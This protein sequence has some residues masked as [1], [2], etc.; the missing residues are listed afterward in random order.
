MSRFDAMQLRSAFACF[1][2]GLMAIGALYDDKPHGLVASSFTSVSL[3]PALVSVCF[4]KT[5]G[6]WQV[7]RQLPR[8][9]LSVLSEDHRAVASELAAKSNDKFVNVAWR[10]S[11]AGAVYV[12]GAGL[13]LECSFFQIVDA[14]DHDVAILE[15]QRVK[16]FPEVSPIVFHA[17][18]YTQLVRVEA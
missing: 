14:G 16:P 1:P 12:D 7:L 15:I 3:E 10:S 8:V 4:G 17:S 5:S 11:E 9:G 18:T 6:T 2:S 13:W